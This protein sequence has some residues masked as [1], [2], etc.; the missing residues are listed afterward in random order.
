M[1]ITKFTQGVNKYDCQIVWIFHEI[2]HCMQIELI[3]FLTL[4]LLSA[5]DIANP[6]K[7]VHIGCK[8]VQKRATCERLPLIIS[9]SY[10]YL[11]NPAFG[12]TD[13]KIAA[14]LMGC[15]CYSSLPRL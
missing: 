7:W 15:G 5:L 9:N 14:I 12:T 10:N 3:A 1:S 11:D 13:K 2:N 8:I 4:K 6:C